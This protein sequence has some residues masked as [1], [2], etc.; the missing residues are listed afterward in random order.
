MSVNATQAA[1]ARVAGKVAIVTGAGAGIG[2]ETALVLARHGAN[3]AI[4]DLTEA[5]G[6]ETVRLIEAEGNVARFWKVN[7]AVESEVKAAT[8]AVVTAF[9]KLDILVN[10]AGV[11]GVDKPTHEITEAEW[12]AVFA[13]D[14]KG[15]FF[16]TKHAVPH[17]Q[18][19]GGGAIVNLSSIYG[20][21]GSHELTPYHAAKGAVTLMSKQD[22]VVY[23]RD[24]IRVNS[25][26]PG[27]ILT[28]LVKELGSRGEGGLEA[29]LKLMGA[30]HPIGHLG[31]PIDV[32]NAILFLV[33]DEARF[34]T[35]AALTVDG[36][37]TAV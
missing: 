26:H 24:N 14:V 32:A 15:V 3:V 30:K 11:T 20:L 21:I 7:V 28:P 36:G 1:D 2:R 4:F 34:I 27:T 31:E 35:G 29:Y 18:K 23:G 22:A 9:G 6:Q 12:D 37:Y 8:D 10:N 16:S 5:D 19:N 33:S 17:L 13:V 25:V